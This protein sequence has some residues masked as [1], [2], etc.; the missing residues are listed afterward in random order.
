MPATAAKARSSTATADDSTADDELL[1]DSTV[2]AADPGL[3]PISLRLFCEDTA[4]VGEPYI[5]QLGPCGGVL[6]LVADQVPF[7]SAASA[8][9]VTVPRLVPAETRQARF[10]RYAA[11]GGNIEDVVTLATFLAAADL[12]EAPRHPVT[13]ET[14]RTSR[15]IDRLA[16]SVRHAVA[17]E[18]TPTKVRCPACGSHLVLER[19]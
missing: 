10:T 6:G 19:I 17:G 2:A 4:C 12:A 14:L 8:R 18:P 5:V 7:W 9:V 3:R 16:S 13:A 1:I 11:S 15:A